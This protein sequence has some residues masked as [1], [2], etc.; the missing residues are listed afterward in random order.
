[1]TNL[2]RR[3]RRRARKIVAD[4]WSERDSTEDTLVERL[5]AALKRERDETSMAATQWFLFSMRKVVDS[6]AAYGRQ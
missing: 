2:E 1:M 6:T 5:A 4:W 3:D